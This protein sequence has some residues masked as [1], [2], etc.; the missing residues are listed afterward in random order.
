MR[1][2][3]ADPDALGPA[4][5]AAHGRRARAWLG[6]R[7]KLSALVVAALALVLIACGIW[8]VQVPVPSSPLAALPVAMAAPPADSNAVVEIAAPSPALN[9]QR[10]D[11]LQPVFA[12][13]DELLATTAST[14]SSAD[15]R[16]LRIYGLIAT[17]R[18]GEA[19]EEAARLT[20]DMPNFGLAQLVYADLLKTMTRPAEGFGAVD[21]PLRAEAAE[22]L[23][24]LVS[25]AR[26]RVVAAGQ[27]PPPA[28][29]PAQF[30]RID[31][32][33]RHAIAVDVS[34]SRLYVFQNTD[35]GLVLKKDYYSSVGKLGFAKQVE[36][37]LRTPLGVYFGTGRIADSRLRDPA[38]EDRYGAAAIALNYPNQYDQMKGRTG[39]G[40]WLH[41][42]ATSLFSRAPLAT[43][44]CVAVANP[45]MLELTQIVERQETPILIA[46]RIEWVDAAVA[47]RRRED[48]IRAFE[49]WKSARISA[50]IDELQQFYAVDDDAGKFERRRAPSLNR[51]TSIDGVSFLWW[52]DDRE[53]FVVSYSENWPGQRRAKQKRQYWLQ[54]EG[55]WKVIFEGNLA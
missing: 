32:S 20:R 47:E 31:R 19:L 39:S 2:A 29:V 14:F 48:F 42:V 15:A 43:D 17:S 4:L 22:R 45:D 18:A 46:E 54:N 51:P 36:G 34:K 27:R 52:Q 3:A 6:G 12:K 50:S 37:D 25:E 26:A 30:V 49:A 1:P 5:P 10:L 28:A 7:R 38:V 11:S 23:R 41:G 8:Q 16:L 44:G 9:A 40:I 24:E 35:R 21:Q 13:G 55:R 33:V 53:V